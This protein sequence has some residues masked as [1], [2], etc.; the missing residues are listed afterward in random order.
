M[1]LLLARAWRLTWAVRAGVIVVVFGGLAVLADGGNVPISMPAAGV[2]LAPVA[3]A[4]AVAAGAAL[5]A[6]DLDVR[7]GSFGWRQPL[8]LLAALAVAFGIVPGAAAVGTGDWNTPST[9]LPTLLDAFLPGSTA[10]GNYN[11]LYVGDARV[12][13]VPG[14]EF[15]DGTSWAM[16]NDDPLDIADRWMPPANGAADAVDTALER[17]ATSSTLRVGQLLAPLGVRYI[18]VPR[19]DGV[20]STPEDPLPLPAGLAEALDDQLDI[21]SVTSLPTLLVYENQAWIPSQALLTGATAEASRAAGDTALVTADLS[22]AAPVFVDADALTPTD[23]DVGPGVVSLA[24][25]YDDNWQ[26]TVGGDQLESRRS[27]GEVTGFDV[28]AGGTAQLGYVTPLSR[29][30]LVLLQTVLWAIAVLAVSRLRLRF[31]RRV[32]HDVVDETL[33][34]LGAPPAVPVAGSPVAGPPLVGSPVEQP[35]SGPPGVGR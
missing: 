27:F 31:D 33:I 21:S 29:P 17:M 32:D 23:G 1:A 12:L 8:G 34:D 19:F 10:A 25:P 26:L 28:D 35:V 14:R 3:M 9:P 20:V 30:V 6:F 7:G 15:R 22:Q 16:T 11:V 4:L 2:L 18:V 13:P 24:V 5:A